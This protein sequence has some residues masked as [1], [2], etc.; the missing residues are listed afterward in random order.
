MSKVFISSVNKGFEEF[1]LA[2]KSA[3]KAAGM[4]PVMVEDFPSQPYSPEQA[5]IKG[6]QESDLCL[7][8]L[9]QRY[10]SVPD[11][12]EISVTH[13]E[14]RKAIEM[15]KPALPFV[16][17]IEKEPDQTAFVAEV[18]DYSK[19]QLRT[20][21]SGVA[22]LK[23]QVTAALEDWEKSQDSTNEAAFLC[24]VNEAL[25]MH[26]PRGY[27]SHENDGE[28]CGVVAFGGR[29]DQ[30]LNLNDIDC[31]AEFQHLCHSGIMSI[32]HEYNEGFNT[33]GHYKL[34]QS[35]TEKHSDIYRTKAAYYDDGLTLLIFMPKIDVRVVASYVSPSKFRQIAKAALHLGRFF[36]SSW[37]MLGLHGMLATYFA[38]PVGSVHATSSNIPP[39]MDIN[40]SKKYF[41]HLFNPITSGAYFNWVE[42][43]IKF[44]EREFGLKNVSSHGQSDLFQPQ[45]W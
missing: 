37:S 29:P 9:G 11:G 35:D 4:K 24:K 27:R 20:K 18:E 43:K 33:G 32:K 25:N 36:N 40:E 21:F 44:F 16:Q 34:I 28:P 41:C 42:A 14:Y 6:V 7:L 12:S 31:D 17:D 30:N 3:V 45:E 1:R 26:H 38:E 8:L 39:R 19:G 23:D 2:A 22:D 10:G 15:H 13:I 5:C